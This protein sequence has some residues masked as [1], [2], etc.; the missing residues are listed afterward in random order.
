MNREIKFRGKRKDNG[1]WVYGFYFE[2]RMSG[3]YILSTKVEAKSVGG[4]LI[5]INVDPTTVGQY[6]GIRD[7]NGK[8]IYEEDIVRCYE[9]N[10]GDEW[11]ARVRYCAD[12]DYP[13]FELEPY[14]DVDCNAISHYQAAGVIEVIGNVHDHPELLEVE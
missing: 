11:V 8:E 9:E 6:I 2:T 3:V 5:H 7:K 12:R 14:P 10:Y 13:A 4:K 1:E